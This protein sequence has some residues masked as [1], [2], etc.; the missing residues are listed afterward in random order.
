MRL[1][2][3]SARTWTY[4]VSSIKEILD[5]G[6]FMVTEQ[7]LS[8]RALDTSR[9]VMVDLYYPKEAFDEF[10]VSDKEGFGVSFDA[11]GKVLTRSLRDEALSIETEKDSLVIS[12]EGHGIRQFKIPQIS[13]NV[14]ELPEPKISFTV[15]AKLSNATF[16]DAIKAV[17]EVADVV[18]LSA[19]EGK[20]YFLGEGDVEKVEVELSLESGNLTDLK[21]DSPDKAKYSV[22]YFDDMIKA[23]RGADQVT[24][25]YAQDSP[26][27]VQFDFE[28]G[29][30]LTF[31]VS[32]RM[33]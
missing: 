7:G 27:R 6:V 26:A 28:G 11:L 19:E 23:A 3:R 25:Q 22:E 17:E 1:K 30:R 24:L 33:D 8:L 13:L 15:Y 12:F 31:Y 21:V 5:E 29:G 18:A 2:F 20:L 14:E 32:P 4:I 16:I 9:V 10:S